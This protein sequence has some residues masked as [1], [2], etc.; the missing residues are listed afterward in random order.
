MTPFQAWNHGIQ[1]TLD[2]LRIF[3][4]TTYVLNKTKTLPRLIIKAWTGYLVA[5]E[6]RHQYHIYDP[7]CEAIFVKRDV[8]FDETLI[9]PKSN[10][11]A[12]D[13]MAVSE[14][15]VTLGFPSLCFLYIPWVDNSPAIL[16]LEH[17]IIPNSASTL[18]AANLPQP[19]S[20]TN[21]N[22]ETILSDSKDELNPP[23]PSSRQNP[24]P[25]PPPSSEKNLAPQSQQKSARL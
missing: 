6:A 12:V 8:I 9:G 13:A 19:N 21:E 20:D 18:L 17:V 2:H 23:P 25:P 24:A 22:N 10:N 5:Y 11:S 3:G 4:S 1:P 7:A 16:L 14:S 15:E